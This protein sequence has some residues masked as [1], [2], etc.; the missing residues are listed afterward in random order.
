MNNQDQKNLVEA[1]ILSSPEPTSIEKLKSLLEHSGV[2]ADAKAVRTIIESLD[3]DC[4]NRGVELKEV[5]SGFRFQV[6]ENYAT[7]MVNLWDNKAQKYSRALLET[8]SLIAYR[9][10]ITRGEIEAIRGVSVST[11]IIKTL[12]ERNWIKILG[13]KDVP[14]RPVIYGTTPSFLAY[15]NLKSLS[16]LPPLPKIDSDKHKLENAPLEQLDMIEEA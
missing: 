6:K 8:L 10:P 5:G 2:Q 1:A 14:G 12:I 16:Q 3:E 13:H 15:F 7:K 4:L 11:H 9:Q